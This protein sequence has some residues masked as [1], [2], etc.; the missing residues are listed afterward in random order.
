VENIKTCFMINN[1]TPV[2]PS[3]MRQCGKIL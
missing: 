2:N 1:S 3:F